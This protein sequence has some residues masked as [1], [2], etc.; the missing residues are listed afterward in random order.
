MPSESLIVRKDED[1][2][3][4]VYIA[5]PERSHTIGGRFAVNSA[6]FSHTT[7]LRVRLLSPALSSGR[8]LSR[9]QRLVHFRKIRSRIE[10]AGLMTT[11]VVTGM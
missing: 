1:G 6:S 11:I 9:Y 2:E 10:I 3:Q 8:N 5:L 7:G 4:T